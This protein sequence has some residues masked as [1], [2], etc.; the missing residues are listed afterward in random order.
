MIPLAPFSLT[1]NN[2]TGLPETQ[3]PPDGLPQACRKFLRKGP[4][5]QSYESVGLGEN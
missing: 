2:K 4:L 3:L 1:G 5:K